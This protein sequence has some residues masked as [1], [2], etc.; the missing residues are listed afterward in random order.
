MARTTTSWK[1]CVVGQ[2][3]KM[4]FRNTRPPDDITNP[5]DVNIRDVFRVYSRTFTR[6]NAAIRKATIVE[7]D[8]N[9]DHNE[10]THGILWGCIHRQGRSHRRNGK[11]EAM[12][13]D[14]DRGKTHKNGYNEHVGTVLSL[15]HQC[16]ASTNHQNCQA[17]VNGELHTFEGYMNTN[18]LTKRHFNGHAI[19]LTTREDPQ[20]LPSKGWKNKEKVEG[21]VS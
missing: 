3:A 11:N 13:T 5:K 14:D 1:Q 20:R 6:G 2:P 18:F 16:G 9:N 10:Q 21:R 4:P 17:R 19:R 7:D 8:A 15:I 12:Y